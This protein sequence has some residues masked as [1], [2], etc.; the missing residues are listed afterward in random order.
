MWLTVVQPER[1]I[2]AKIAT[3]MYAVI[4]FITYRV[5]ILSGLSRVGYLAFGEPGH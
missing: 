2:V 5:V 1:A 3:V 4:L